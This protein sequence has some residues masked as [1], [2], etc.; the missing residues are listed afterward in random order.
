MYNRKYKLKTR[1]N[2]TRVELKK[3]HCHEERDTR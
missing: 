1:Y 3:G 2:V